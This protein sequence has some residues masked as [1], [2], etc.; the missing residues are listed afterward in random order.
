MMSYLRRT[1]VNVKVQLSAI[2]ENVHLVVHMDDKSASRAVAA[3]TLKKKVG[4]PK[5]S[6][7]ASSLGD[8]G[9]KKRAMGSA[10]SFAATKRSKVVGMYSSQ[11]AKAYPFKLPQL[12]DERPDCKEPRFVS[13]FGPA[14]SGKSTYLRRIHYEWAVGGGSAMWGGKIRFL[15]NVSVRD[16]ESNP[17]YHGCSVAE[18]LWGTALPPDDLVGMTVEQFTSV[19]EQNRSQV[20]IMYVMLHPNSLKKLMLP[21]S[22]SLKYIYIFSLVLINYIIIARSLNV[23]VA[24]P[25]CPLPR[26]QSGAPPF[27]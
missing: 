16:A 6:M 1:F 8:L 20:C 12:F 27:E 7:V 23:S 25:C 15:F 3:A 17:A 21:T 11:K 5:K 19:L 18:L 24:L 26:R 4:G 22:D 14:G 2:F 9:I 10:P 13:I